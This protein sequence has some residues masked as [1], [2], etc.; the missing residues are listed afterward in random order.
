FC[1]HRAKKSRESWPVT[2]GDIL[3]SDVILPPT[4]TSDD[5]ADATTTIRYRYRVGSMSFENDAVNS[6][7]RIPMVRA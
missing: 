1:E 4:H 3:A 2:A 7:N 5:R 6:G